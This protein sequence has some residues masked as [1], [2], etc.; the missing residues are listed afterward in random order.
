MNFLN[1]ICSFIASNCYKSRSNTNQNEN[2]MRNSVVLLITLLIAGFAVTAEAKEAYNLD[3]E[4]VNE[5]FASAEQ[6]DGMSGADNAFNAFA[7]Q[8]AEHGKNPGVAFA[9]A[10]T[11]GPLGIH[12]FYLGTSVG[13]GLGYIFTLGGCGIV[14]TVDWVLLLIEV[15]EEDNFEQY[16]NNPSFFMW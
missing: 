7:L 4:A 13:T 8:D 12:R 2:S 1:S 14:A 3:D 11:L 9:L 10:W 15:I 6:V 16:V 5:L